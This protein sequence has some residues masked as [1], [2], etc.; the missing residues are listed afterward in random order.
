LICSF[1]VLGFNL[2]S[3]VIV[4]D[5]L[6]LLG[7]MANQV[8]RDKGEEGQFSHCCIAPTIRAILTSRLRM[9]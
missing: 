3:K 4:A 9:R 7:G 1:S 8:K 2:L 5:W 6:A